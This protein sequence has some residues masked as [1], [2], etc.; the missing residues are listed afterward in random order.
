MSTHHRRAGGLGF[1]EEVPPVF[2]P[3]ALV[4][5]SP[6]SESLGETGGWERQCGLRNKT[7][8]FAGAF[9]SGVGQLSAPRMAETQENERERVAETETETETETERKREKGRS[10]NGVDQPIHD[11]GLSFH[12]ISRRSEP[13][14]PAAESDVNSR[15]VH[16][17]CATIFEYS[18]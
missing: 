12:H 15:G 4:Q 3:A 17:I 2:A 10:E 18:R 16:L 9:V 1:D 6:G 5:P 13:V 11:A 8:A 7:R 14:R